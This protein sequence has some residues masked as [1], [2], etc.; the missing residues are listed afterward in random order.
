MIA[1]AI[2]GN[3]ESAKQTLLQGLDVNTKDSF[4]SRTALHWSAL[5]GNDSMVDLLIQNGA[6][7]NEKDNDGN[8][9]LNLAASRGHDGV[10]QKLLLF[11]ANRTLK[12]SRLK[13]PL[14]TAESFKHVSTADILR[15][16]HPDSVS[17]T[18]NQLQ[19]LIEQ[20]ERLR[21]LLA[22]FNMQGLDEFPR[23]SS[24]EEVGAQNRFFDNL[25]VSEDARLRRLIEESGNSTAIARFPDSPP[26]DSD[27]LAAEIRALQAVASELG[28]E[29]SA[30]ALL[31]EENAKLR[32]GVGIGKHFFCCCLRT[33]FQ[34]MGCPWICFSN[35]ES[36]EDVSARMK[37]LC[38]GRMLC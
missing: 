11:G 23:L 19:V 36:L 37:N 30:L 38:L 22:S 28:L 16:F 33:S 25:M 8:T 9:P 26:L 29:K 17:P 2:D 31:M 18:G 4:R 3:V 1:D 27:H 34:L 15:S 14:D 5:H 13:T 6:A 21:R 12:N 24:V 20:N 35:M 7:V 32:A 10:V